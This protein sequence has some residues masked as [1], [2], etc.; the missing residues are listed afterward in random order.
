VF[1]AIGYSGK[2]CRYSQA[3][4]PLGEFSVLGKSKPA[5]SKE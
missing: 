4:W 3:N 2:Y 5:E 1:Q